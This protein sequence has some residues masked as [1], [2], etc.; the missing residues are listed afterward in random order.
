MANQA[1]QRGIPRDLWLLSPSES[2][3]INLNDVQRN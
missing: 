1:Y 2:E 3:P